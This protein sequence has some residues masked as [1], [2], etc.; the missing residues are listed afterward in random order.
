MASTTPFFSIVV[1][2]YNR[3]HLISKTLQSLLTQS[4][5]DFEVLVVDD[6]S[7]DIERLSQIISELDDERF[8]LLKHEKNLNGAAARNTGINA[9]KGKYIAFLDSDDTWPDKRLAAMRAAIECTPEADRVV[10]YGQVDFKFP[11]QSHGRIMPEV[12]I[13]GGSVA[14]YL[15]IHGGLIQTSTIVCSSA[16]AKAVGFDERFIR[17]QDYDF[18]LRAEANGYLFKFIPHV[19][20]NWLRYKGA[21]T[22]KKGATFDFCKFW[23]AEMKQYM[24]ETASKNYQAKV[25][26]P[27]AFE[28][29]NLAE[30]FAILCASLGQVS[31]R[32]WPTVLLKSIKGLIKYFIRVIS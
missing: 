13:G 29:G 18:C 6:C 23:L 17:H 8:S 11:E 25:L 9:S 28:T 27:I 24:S 22:F 26:A 3:A 2:T 32:R 4:E 12:G 21:S 20:S 31:L 16:L 30:G 10:F 15:F 14:E 1:P 5:Q 7:G 19:V